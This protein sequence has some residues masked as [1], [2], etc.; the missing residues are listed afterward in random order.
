MNISKFKDYLRSNKKLR[1]YKNYYDEFKYNYSY[2]S[3]KL[4]FEKQH[5]K[6]N[7]IIVPKNQLKE[8]LNLKLSNRIESKQFPKKRGELRILLIYTN[9]NWEELL[10][11]VFK[12]F[13][14]VY[15]YEFNSRGF[16]TTKHDWYKYKKIMNDDLVKYYSTITYDGPIDVVI[17]MICGHNTFEKTLQFMKLQGSVLINFTYDDRVFFRK[18]IKDE[19]QSQAALARVIDLNLTNC[20]ESLIK[21]AY[22]GGLAMHMPE[23]AHPSIHYPLN[24]D[25]QYDV[26]FIGN[27]SGWR[28]HFIKCLQKVGINVKCF[29]RGWEAGEVSRKKMVEI[30]NT[31]RVNLGTAFNGPAR[32]ILSLKGRDFEIPMCGGLYLTEYSDEIGK[33]YKLNEEILVY[34]D[35]NECKDQIQ[36]VL[37]NPEKARNIAKAGYLRAIKDHTYEVRWTEIFKLCNLI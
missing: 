37:R 16:D 25:F 22:Y 6:N 31:S 9:T 13:G 29:G 24:R 33:C 12:M 10:P 21:Y 19:L 20:E 3:E 30:F 35:I 1:N 7:F 17:G 5:Q 28:P 26:T 11:D 27:N 4:F 8:K 18:K 2:K 15:V 32:K 34:K 23:S 14:T 36:W